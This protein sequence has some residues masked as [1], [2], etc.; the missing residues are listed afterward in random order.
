MLK[1]SCKPPFRKN[2]F[3]LKFSIGS[4]FTKMKAQMKIQDENMY[5]IILER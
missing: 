1:F 5:A 4:Y 3:G 2:L